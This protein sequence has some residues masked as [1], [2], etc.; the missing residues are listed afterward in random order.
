MSPEGDTCNGAISSRLSVELRQL[1]RLRRGRSS[2]RPVIGFLSSASSTIRDPSALRSE[3]YVEGQNIVSNIG[4]RKIN[5]TNFRL[6]HLNWFRVR[7]T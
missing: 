3:S 4:G 6:L 5:T 1:G 2:R 7:W